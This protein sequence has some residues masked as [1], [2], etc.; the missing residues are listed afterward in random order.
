[1]TVDR[2]P[3]AITAAP[4][5]EEPEVGAPGRAPGSPEPGARGVAPMVLPCA[6]GRSLVVRP[7]VASDAEGLMDLYHRLDVE[8]RCRR[9]FTASAPAMRTVERIAAVAD[10]GGQGLVA[11]D[12][13]EPSGPGR[14]VAEASCSPLADGDGEIAITVDPTWRGWL[15]PYLLDLLVEIAAERG[16]VNVEAEILTSNRRMLVLARHRGYVTRGHGDWSTVRVVMG[17]RAAEPVW[18]DGAR[19]PRVLVEA[20]GGRWRAEDELRRSGASVLV[21]PGPT[22]RHRPC[23]ALAARPCPLAAGADV[24]VLAPASGRPGWDRLA[25]AHAA[26]HPETPVCLA[27][28]SESA[29]SCGGSDLP[30]D[31]QAAA[32][33]VMAVCASAGSAIPSGG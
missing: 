11:V 1:M 17:A 15:G 25:D 10:R 8:D 29:S 33:A 24:I 23:P 13:G 27:R 20:P 21:C 22:G 2:S 32:D 4:E 28:R 18:P 16:V 5:A 14:I 6:G 31:P 12:L 9:F 7:M 3:P 19:R 26:L 30:R